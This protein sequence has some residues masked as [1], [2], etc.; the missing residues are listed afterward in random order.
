MRKS[1][2][3]I[4]NLSGLGREAKVLVAMAFRNGPIEDIHAGKPCPECHGHTEYSHITQSE[5]RQIMKTAVDRMYTFLLLKE[6]D[7]KAYEALL[8]VG[9][10]YTTA[11]DEPTLTTE[12]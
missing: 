1:A 5:M 9:Q 10:M 2:R 8:T 11:R 6:T 12:F 7:P 4:K 3:Q